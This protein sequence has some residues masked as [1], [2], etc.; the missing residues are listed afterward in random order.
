MSASHPTAAEA[1][2]IDAVLE[3]TSLGEFYTADREFRGQV[4][5]LATVVFPALV[6]SCADTLVASRLAELVAGQL[7]SERPGDG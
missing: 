2:M 3:Q 7:G 4:D 5:H 6:R 1:T